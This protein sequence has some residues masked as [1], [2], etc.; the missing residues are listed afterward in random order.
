VTL[1]V[2]R[3][4]A[5]LKAARKLLDSGAA[6]DR[7]RQTV[8][9]GVHLCAAYLERIGAPDWCLVGA[10]A[11]ELPEVAA[12]VARLPEKKVLSVRDELLGQTSALR[13]GV[14]LMF[15]INLPAAPSPPAGDVDTVLIDRL[16]DPGNLGSILRSSAAFGFRQV[17]LSD[18]SVAAWSP[19]VLRAAMG[20]HFA[21]V[22]H[23]H[24]DLAAWIRTAGNRVFATSSHASA[25]LSDQRLEASPCGFLFGHEGQGV[26]AELMA[27]CAPVRIAQPGG[28][29][30]LNVAAAAAICL[31]EVVRQRR[32]PA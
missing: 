10:Q 23:E 32:L 21:L 14:A 18:Q 26:A 8:L 29:E 15:V 13:H 25:E 11:L 7:Q 16:Q 22:I 9:E 24:C 2:S 12:L 3:D 30:S 17:L 5:R 4:N 1:I 28:E 31:F 20:A 19:K 27:L 6:R